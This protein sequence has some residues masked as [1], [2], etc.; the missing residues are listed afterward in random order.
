MDARDAEWRNHK[1]RAS[2]VH[3][4]RDLAY[5]VI[6]DIE[7]SKIDTAMV[8]KVLEQP[9]GGTTL[10]LA[11]TETAARLRGRIEAVLDRAKVLGLREG[12]NP[13]RWKGHLEHLLPKKSKVAPVVHHAA[14][15]YRQIGAFVAELR[16]P[17]GTAA[18]ALEFLIL[19]L[20]RR[21]RSSVP[22]GPKSTG[23]KRS[24]RSRPDA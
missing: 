24:G 23:R 3:T 14:L 5:P 22:S 16:Q 11:R 4:L 12:E 7:P 17:D 19:N 20:S 15:D 9:R 8:V 13:A 2:W 18:R 6:G 10:W 21:A 1:S